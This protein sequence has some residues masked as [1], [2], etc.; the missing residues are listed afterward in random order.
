MYIDGFGFDNMLTD[1]DMVE[2]MGHKNSAIFHN[3]NIG[4]H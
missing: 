4:I 2:H 3:T 1:Y